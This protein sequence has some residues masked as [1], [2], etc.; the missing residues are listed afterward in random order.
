MPENCSPGLG[1]SLDAALH[2]ACCAIRKSHRSPGCFS[3]VRW[4][5]SA[6]RTAPESIQQDLREVKLGRERPS[7][8]NFG[9]ESD[10]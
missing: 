3:S 8:S 6:F 4:S 1:G 5:A 9:V 2:G 10:V 7:N